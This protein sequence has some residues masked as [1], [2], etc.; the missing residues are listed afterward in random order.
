MCVLLKIVKGCSIFDFEGGAQ[1]HA[2][3]GL[4]I[5][6]F[7]CGGSS[8][9]RGF[10]F[11]DVHR[12]TA[13]ALRH[14]AKSTPCGRSELRV[15]WPSTNTLAFIGTVDQ[16]RFQKLCLWTKLLESFRIF[17]FSNSA[18]QHHYHST[19]SEKRDV[20]EDVLLARSRCCSGVELRSP[21]AMQSHQRHR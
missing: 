7:G 6:M 5:G 1:E 19:T 4:L 10:T 14:R 8:S 12:T 3:Y 16:Q 21:V 17:V 9:W 11:H 13:A 15:S 20:T 18:S 2:A